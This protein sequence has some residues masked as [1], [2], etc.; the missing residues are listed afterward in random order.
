M[1][2]ET[3]E[4]IVQGVSVQE[5]NECV[6]HFTSDNVTA[7]DTLDN[8]ES[9]IDSF[10]TNIMPLWLACMPVSYYVDRLAAR[11]VI[12]KPSAVA[13]RQYENNEQEG[14]LDSNA[15][16][17]QLCPSVLLIP[18]TGTKSA[19]RC[20]M[21]SV[22]RNQIVDNLYIAGYQTVIDALFA[23]MTANF[24]VSG[25]HWQLAVY[26]RKFN[27]ATLAQAWQLS[28]RLGFQKNRRAPV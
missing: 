2:T 18:P 27:S 4:L 13:H 21:P 25:K 11:R 19:G 3:Y 20:F 10:H 15:A 28:S 7:N 23:A 1:A 22:G 14:T 26:S 12:T 8:G 6:L 16:S 5:R 9:L 24:G 17:D